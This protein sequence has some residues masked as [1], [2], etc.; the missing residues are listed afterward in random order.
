MGLT[1]LLMVLFVGI[2][3]RST[4]ESLESSWVDA[5]LFARQSL[6]HG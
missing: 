6:L 4:V 5:S 3:F 1:I 2:I